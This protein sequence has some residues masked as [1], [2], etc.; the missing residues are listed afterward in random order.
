[1]PYVRLGNAN[2][3]KVVEF[4]VYNDTDNQ[5][6]TIYYMK[7]TIC[8]TQ[9]TMVV[10]EIIGKLPENIEESFFYRLKSVAETVLEN[11]N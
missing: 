10:S 9:C 6:A 11:N 1:M 4:F 3:S 7:K 8:N 5:C 2:N